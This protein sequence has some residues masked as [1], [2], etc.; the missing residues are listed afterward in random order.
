[1]AAKR[2]K[3]KVTAVTPEYTRSVNVDLDR[4]KNGYIVSTWDKTGAIKYIAKTKKEAMAY[5]NKL[6]NRR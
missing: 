4:A 2:K 1:M 6:L 5:A 3:A